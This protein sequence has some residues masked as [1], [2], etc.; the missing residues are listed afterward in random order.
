ML[1][2]QFL[3]MCSVLEA[4]FLLNN[5]RWNMNEL[6]NF[7]KIQLFTFLNMNLYSFLQH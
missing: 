5:V 6:S 4:E 1:C 3:K 2:Y 7:L